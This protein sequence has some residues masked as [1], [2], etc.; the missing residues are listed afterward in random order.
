MALMQAPSRTQASS[1]AARHANEARLWEALASR[2]AECGWAHSY[3]T[4][5]AHTQRAHA[6]A[7]R[8]RADAFSTKKPS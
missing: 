3:Y 7:A 2:S 4:H 5:Q 6:A 8:E 1:H